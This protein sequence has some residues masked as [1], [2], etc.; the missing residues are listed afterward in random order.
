[1]PKTTEKRRGTGKKRVKDPNAPKRPLSAFFWF[2]KD[3]RAEVKSKNPAYTVG[4]IAKALGKKWADCT[5]ED[6]AKY[7]EMA[8]QDKD[9]Y[10][11]EMFN[12][13][14][15]QEGSENEGD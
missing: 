1:M 5:A 3:E 9:R 7:A 6:K 11:K 8:E 12:Y 14:K 4:D 15:G 10:D 13:R 2:C